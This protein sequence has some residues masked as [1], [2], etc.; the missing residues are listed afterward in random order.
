MKNQPRRKFIQQTAALTS[1]LLFMDSIWNQVL[2]KEFTAF[3][4]N[5]NWN[6][7]SDGSFDLNSSSISFKNAYP[8][9]NGIAIKPLSI[10]VTSN[11][12]KYKLSE[13]SITIDLKVIEGNPVLSSRIE[14][15]SQA[16]HWFQPMAGAKVIGIEKFFYQGLGFGGPSGFADLRDPI[17]KS[18]IKTESGSD[19]TWMLE[20]YLLS[21]ILA[22]DGTTLAVAALDHRNFLQK[23]TLY[24]HEQRW[25]LINRHLLNEDILFQAEFSTEEIPLPDKKLILPDLHFVM[26]ESAWNAFTS[27]AGKIA[28]EMK[29]Q[30]MK[31]PRYHWCSWYIRQADFSFQD[32]RTFYEGVNKVRPKPYFQTV[33]I[34]DGYEKYY[35]D[36]LDFKDAWPDGLK[37][38]F[39]LIKKNDHEA[40]VWVGAFMVHR[41]SK[42][43]KDHPDWVLKK[44]DGTYFEEMGGD[45]LVLDTSHPDAFNYLRNVF[46][47]M[48][49][50]GA[51]FYKTDFMD[52]GLQDSV[53]SK[54]Y[55]PGKTSVQYFRDV[56]QMIREEIGQESY[57]LACISPFGPFLGYADGVRVAND[58]PTSWKGINNMFEQMYNLHYS[59]NILWQNDP[60]VMF[61]NNKVV[62][63]TDDELKSIAYFMGIMGGSV[64]TSEWL[65]DE[66]SAKFWQFLAP[67][68][69][70]SQAL[71]PFYA[72]NKSLVVVVRD[73]EK[74]RAKGILIVNA[75]DSKQNEKLNLKEIAGENEY[76]IFRWDRDGSSLLDKK[77]FIEIELEPHA[78]SLLYLSKENTAPNSKL[79]IGGLLQK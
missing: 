43:F 45:G 29:V 72:K 22:K 26:T 35:G 58:T 33:Q 46:K 52:W 17:F 18:P 73:Y 9:I 6:I 8:A 19:E 53:K 75:T 3:E 66:K 21:G 63:F 5:L 39:D 23:S 7:N 30:P 14:G 34:D 47:T 49:K 57:W 37:P 16:P 41:K 2:S 65:N 61:L 68:E 71:L 48:R 74:Q 28:K 15:I 54:R 79:S 50:N 31:K 13:G 55:K 70:L 51:T 60:D 62:K 76:Y 1:G 64:N 59:N 20:S 44:A 12:I 56:L 38:A 4:N 77:Q 27:M 11:N 10:E 24:N 42:L 32:L 25:G 69:N 40:G 78:C 67:Q 36:W